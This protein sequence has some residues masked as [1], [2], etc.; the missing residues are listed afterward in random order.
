MT[1]H[2]NCFLFLIKLQRPI[3]DDL[4]P[5][6]RRQIAANPTSVSVLFPTNTMIIFGR[7][8]CLRALSH[9]KKVML[10]NQHKAC[11]CLQKGTNNLIVCTRR[12][13]V[14]VV[15]ESFFRRNNDNEKKKSRSRRTTENIKG[16]PWF[17]AAYSVLFY[18]NRRGQS[19]LHLRTRLP[20]SGLWRIPNQLQLER[21]IFQNESLMWGFSFCFCDLI[22]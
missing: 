11:L 18:E 17:S 4:K 19:H 20:L 7:V 14:K 15:L 12:C 22:V 21:W 10:A 1:D 2:P 5:Q 16:Q 3:Y 8:T 13:Q 6:T 9:V